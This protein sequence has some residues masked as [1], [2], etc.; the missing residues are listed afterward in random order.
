MSSSQTATEAQRAVSDPNVSALLPQSPTEDPLHLSKLNAG[1]E[2][3]GQVKLSEIVLD[4]N[5]HF[6]SPLTSEAPESGRQTTHRA[7]SPVWPV[8]ITVS[9]D[10]CAICLDT[11]EDEIKVRGLS[12]DHAFHVNCVDKWLLWRRAC[13]PVCRFVCKIPPESDVKEV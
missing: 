3:Q 11:M 2:A 9:S 13:C 5:R 7:L 4:K 12:C 8:G 1:V 10:V 6:K